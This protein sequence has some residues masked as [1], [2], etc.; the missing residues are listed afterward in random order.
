LEG[1]LSINQGLL[2]YDFCITIRKGTRA[3][4]IKYVKKEKNLG[5][6]PKI[7]QLRENCTWWRKTECIFEFSAKSSIKIRCFLSCYQKKKV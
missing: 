4:G 2:W 6:F 5:D 7:S 3:R 1:L